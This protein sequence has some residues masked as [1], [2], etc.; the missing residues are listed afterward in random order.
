MFERDDT[1]A[2]V[3]S[4]WELGSDD[5]ARCRDLEVTVRA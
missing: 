2:T 3:R 5:T 1:P 4:Q